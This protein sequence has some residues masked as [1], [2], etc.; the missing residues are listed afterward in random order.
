MAEIILINPDD[1]MERK[2]YGNST[3]VPVEE[4]ELYTEA[5]LYGCYFH[6]FYNDRNDIAWAKPGTWPTEPGIYSV[7][8]D[9]Q[10][11]W[12][13]LWLPKDVRQPKLKGLIV[14]KDDE[15]MIEDAKGKYLLR[16]NY[17]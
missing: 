5:L 12:L 8:A 17:V 2:S 4:L 13:Y 14:R 15:K 6:G 1:E 16:A 10:E 11:C 9:G 3:S 7:I